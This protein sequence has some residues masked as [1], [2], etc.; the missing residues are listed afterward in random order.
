M[1][2]T[3]EYV[4]VPPGLLVPRRGDSDPYVLW[5][6]PMA[7]PAVQAAVD[8]AAALARVLVCCRTETEARAAINTVP[9]FEGTRR[10][11]DALENVARILAA[12]GTPGEAAEHWPHAGIWVAH[13]AFVHGAK[14]AQRA[15][16]LFRAMAKY[17]H[18]RTKRKN[19][20]PF[21][22]YGKVGR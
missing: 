3:P 1:A 11:A 10:R 21:L 16:G 17:L 14:A 12:G 18:F 4:I 6:A 8:T 5:T 22:R 15:S 9:E 2:K 19:R 20:R 7:P 13:C